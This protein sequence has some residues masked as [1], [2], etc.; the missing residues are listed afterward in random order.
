MILKH[1]KRIAFGYGSAGPIV[2]GVIGLLDGFIIAAT[3]CLLRGVNLI[4]WFA[5]R[6]VLR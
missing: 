2:N 6:H 3:P 4:V 5:R 1:D